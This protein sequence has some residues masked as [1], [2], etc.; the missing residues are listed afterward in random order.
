MKFRKMYAIQNIFAVE[1]KLYRR[2]EDPGRFTGTKLKKKLIS[3]VGA[4][5]DMVSLLN[6]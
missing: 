6:P 4:N 2:R 5:S 1:A 3:L